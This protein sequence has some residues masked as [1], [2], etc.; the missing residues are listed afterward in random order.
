MG[1][2]IMPGILTRIQLPSYHPSNSLSNTRVDRN[3]TT[4][5]I[6]TQK[7]DETLLQIITTAT[8]QQQS[9]SSPLP[10]PPPPPRSHDDAT[11]SHWGPNNTTIDAIILVHDTN[12]DET[13]Q[14]LEY[15]WLQLIEKCYDGKVSD[16]QE[17][18]F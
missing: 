16:K 8:S 12:H 11:A 3:I 1:E 6:D 15:H 4:T 14:R 17:P 10:P 13:F 5:I 18:I 7:A 2:T 9:S